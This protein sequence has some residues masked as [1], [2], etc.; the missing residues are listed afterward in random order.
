LIKR[1]GS[2]TGTPPEFCSGIPH[3]LGQTDTSTRNL[4]PTRQQSG[5]KLGRNATIFQHAWG[6]HQL[7]MIDSNTATTT[8][9]IS[10]PNTLCALTIRRIELLTTVV[11]VAPKVAE[12][13]I[14][15]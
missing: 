11:S 5:P 7:T 12:H 13:P 10:S 1:S 2:R 3:S 14:A 4:G 6:A 8:V 15:R 9:F